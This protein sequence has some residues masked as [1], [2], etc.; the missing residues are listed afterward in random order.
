M[1]FW[2]IIIVLIGLWINYCIISTDIKRFKGKHRKI[3]Y[4]SSAAIEFIPKIERTYGQMLLKNGFATIEIDGK[5]YTQRTGEKQG[6]NVSS[7]MHN[8]KCYEGNVGANIGV[9]TT[10]VNIP[11]KHICKIKYTASMTG[12]FAGRITCKIVKM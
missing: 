8:I 10:T 7:G 12:A 6:Y 5:C 9:A 2:I 1:V 11:Q 3:T 4:Q